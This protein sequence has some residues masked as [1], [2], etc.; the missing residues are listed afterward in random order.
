MTFRELN[1]G[2]VFLCDGVAMIKIKP[3]IK[4]GQYLNCKGPDGTLHYTEDDG[5]TIVESIDD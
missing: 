3:V 4:N 2:D 1:E 5:K